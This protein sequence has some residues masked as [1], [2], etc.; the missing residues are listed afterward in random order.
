M[1]HNPGKLN[2]LFLWL[3]LVEVATMLII[4]VLI[5]IIDMCLC[6]LEVLL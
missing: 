6:V 5:E 4:N 2:C 1:R 3:S